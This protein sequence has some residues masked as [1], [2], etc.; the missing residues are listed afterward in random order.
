MLLRPDMLRDIRFGLRMLRKSP[1][2][3]AVAALSLGLG[4][5]ANTT[6]FS[7]A[8]A[9][10]FRPLAVER[11]GELVS[12]EAVVPEGRRPKPFPH[13]DFVDFRAQAPKNFDLAA[14][15]PSFFS[16]GSASKE[17]ERVFGSIVSGNFFRLLGVQ[18]AAGRLLR[19]EDDVG[20]APPVV[21]LSHS[22]WKRRFD[23]DPS[24]T[25]RFVT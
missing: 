25:G 15:S 21:V 10:L 14:F 6:I 13:A 12:V 5:G 7:V 17:S 9:L 1:G 2:F 8:N 22:L 19:D 18:P 16:L 4:I 11:A 24:V 3:T 23:S 20:G